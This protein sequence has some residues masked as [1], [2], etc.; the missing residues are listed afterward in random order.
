MVRSL[1]DKFWKEDVY[2]SLDTKIT[3]V[4]TFPTVTLCSVKIL[5][6]NMYCSLQADGIVPY[7]VAP[8]CRQYGY[9]NA[10]KKK[11]SKSIDSIIIDRGI[12][13]QEL[14]A[15]N[16]AAMSFTCP[17]KEA[18]L[19]SYLERDYFNTDDEFPSC[20]TWN[21]AGNFNNTDN[22]ISFE[23]DTG[24]RS[25]FFVY[26]HDHRESPMHHGL[27]IMLSNKLNAQL[28][29]LLYTSPSPRDS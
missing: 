3:S 6:K 4:N 14:H 15:D 17:T 13:F 7:Y 22:I 12:A 11:E 10:N 8:A 21:W 27:P 20:V 16:Q 9:W 24:K 19:D 25:T 2:K 5:I 1:I 26:I 28:T 23:I 29:C 18:C